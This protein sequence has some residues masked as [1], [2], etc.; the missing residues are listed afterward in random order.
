[1]NTEP[2]ADSSSTQPDEQTI[3]GST[4]TTDSSST[5]PDEQTIGDSTNTADSSSTQPDEQTIG[6]S[7]N[8]ADSSST[9]PDEQT[10]GDSTNTVA[11][12]EAC[13]LNAD[14]DALQEHLENNQTEQ[15]MLDRCLMIGLQVVQRKEQEMGRVAPALQLLW[16][17]GAKW[18]PDS[19]LKQQ[20]TPLHL[21][22]KSAGDH[23]DLLDLLIRS[24][25]LTL[26]N[27]KD[28]YHRTA[29]M[30]AVK[31]ANINCLKSLIAH[32]AEMKTNND[33]KNLIILAIKE[34]ADHS[35]QSA[36]IMTEI[37]DVLLDN[38]ADVNKALSQAV[39][40]GR[41]ECIKKLIVKGANID[42]G[43]GYVWRMTAGYGVDM[44]NCL[45]DRGIDKDITDQ[46]GKS[47][48]WWV[49]Q[50]SKVGTIR[51]LLDQGVKVPT[52]V[53]KT[54]H[55]ECKHCGVELL[56]LDT[57]HQTQD[58]SMK[59]IRRDK[60]DVVQLFEEYGSETFKHFNAFR[61]AVIYDSVTVLEYLHGSYRHP[62][63]I[64]YSVSKIQ[65]NCKHWTLLKES[66]YYRSIRSV[67]YLLEHGADLNTV[68][69][70]SSAFVIAI[71]SRQIELVALLICNGVDINFRSYNGTYGLVLPFEAAILRH[72]ILNP[73]FFYAVELLLVSGCSCGVFNLEED[74]KW[75]DNVRIET[76]NLM[77]KWNVHE[78]NVKPL[79]QQCRRMTLKHLSPRASKMIEKLPLPQCLIKYLSIPELDDIVDRYRSMCISCRNYTKTIHGLRFFH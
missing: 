12:L 29:L 48:L 5:Q 57:K 4:N 8:T 36:I 59:A 63:N 71:Q 65:S 39:S 18:N 11:L 50:D 23:Y 26:L 61:W 10:I 35:K 24:S 77:M 40:L 47:L 66:C 6:D 75:K 74:H 58:P 42:Y 25:E 54:S 7:T 46:Q 9:Q 37:F 79:K 15:S 31:N 69:R 30:Y 20:M 45:F 49:T 22:C 34:L 52:Y 43:N 62:L 38:G 70:C 64:S 13:I 2:A 41:V 44:L 3:G 55:D 28:Y 56:V 16:Q 72:N 1:M 19:L 17:S 67:H 27:A 53:S 76:K 14:H 60:V 51:Y 21:I 33:K 78:N 73:S 68:D 32:G